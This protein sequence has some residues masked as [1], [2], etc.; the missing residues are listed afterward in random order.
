MYSASEILSQSTAVKIACCFCFD[1]CR[2][3]DIM[4]SDYTFLFIAYTGTAAMEVAGLTI[5][6]AAFLMSDWKLSDND[7]SIRDFF[8]N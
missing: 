1:F 8:A 2:S 3:A 4:W 7:I 6:K 5:C